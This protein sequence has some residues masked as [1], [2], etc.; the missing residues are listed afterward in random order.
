MKKKRNPMQPVVLAEDWIIR[1]QKNDIVVALP[2][3]ASWHGFSLSDLAKMQFS[4]DDRA[5]L[6]QLIGYSV[7]GFGDLSYVS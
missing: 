6:A 2:R 7:S 1:F 3:C 5:Q 4:R